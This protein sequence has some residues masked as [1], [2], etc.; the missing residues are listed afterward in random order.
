MNQTNNAAIDQPFRIHYPVD[1]TSAVVLD[2]PHS[3]RNFPID[4]GHQLSESQLRSGED[5]D[6]HVLYEKAPGVG[7][8]FLE[9]LF[10]RTYIDPNRAAGDVDLALLDRPWPFTE[11]PYAFAPSGKAAIGKALIWRTIDDATPIYAGLMTPEQ[12]KYRIDHYLLPYQNSLRELIEKAHLHRG[13]SVH[14]NCHSMEP[15]GGAMAQGGQGRVR[16][17]VVLGDR[18]GSTCSPK[19]TQLVKQFF[20][21]EGYAVAVNDPYKGVE[22]VRYFSEPA[23]GRH[24][25]QIELN[26]KLYLKYPNAA[27]A[28]RPDAFERSDHFY[29]LQEQLTR[30]TSLLVELT[31][32][33]PLGLS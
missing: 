28:G 24:S 8:A 30:L 27:L 29:V 9:A 25:L 33:S 17:D 23:V 31:N 26:K 15:V 32:Q 7:A 4:F 16:A 21:K 5:V 19:L 14:I 13:V 1:Q 20:E 2:S 18:D 12:V 11:A 22:L 6:I 3:G 10:P